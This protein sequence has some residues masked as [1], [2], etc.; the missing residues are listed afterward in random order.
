MSQ[1]NRLESNLLALLWNIWRNNI[2]T[3][4]CILNLSFFQVLCQSLHRP[5]NPCCHHGHPSPHNYKNP[6]H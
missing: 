1:R 5:F 6:S 2:L 3:I 4:Y